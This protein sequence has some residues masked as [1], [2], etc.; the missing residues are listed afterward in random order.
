MRSN[1]SSDW[2]PRYIKATR[3][4]LEIFKMDGYFLDSLRTFN[5]LGQYVGGKSVPLYDMKAYDGLKVQ[6]PSFLNWALD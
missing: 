4:V 2:L 5:G 3:T 6:L 1:V